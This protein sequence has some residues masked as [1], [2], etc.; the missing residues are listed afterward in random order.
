[1]DDQKAQLE[2]SLKEV[3]DLVDKLQGQ[4]ELKAKV[5]ALSDKVAAAQEH[6]PVA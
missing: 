2:A 3:K 6:K 1:M 5:K 4:D